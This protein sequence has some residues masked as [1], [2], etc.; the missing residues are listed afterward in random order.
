[1]ADH[2]HPSAGE[3]R[4]TPVPARCRY[5]ITVGGEPA[6]HADY[7]DDGGRRIFHHTEID[8]RFSGRGLGGRLVAAAL[9]YARATGHRIVAVCPFV[10]RYLKA[11]PDYDDI[12][13]PVTPKAL[14]AVSSRNS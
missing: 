3:P 7:I 5:D 9:A 2:Q 1:M 11:H 8:E 14:D 6:G 12:V 13:D 4:V 10:A